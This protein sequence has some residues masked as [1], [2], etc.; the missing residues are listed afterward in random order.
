MASLKE[1]SPSVYYINLVHIEGGVTSSLKNVETGNGTVLPL[2]VS[3]SKTRATGP[4]EAA[5]RATFENELF[6]S[7]LTSG[8]SGA[9]TVLVKDSSNK[10]FAVP[11]NLISDFDSGWESLDTFVATTNEYGLNTHS[12][13]P[14]YYAG[15]VAAQTP[16]Y[17]LVNRHMMFS[18]PLVIP[19]TDGSTGF[20][21]NYSTVI[22]STE[23][24]VATG[25]SGW[26]HDSDGN[27]DF[28][29]SP[30]L[31]QSA[32]LRPDRYRDFGWHIA[33][34]FMKVNTTS[35]GVWLTALVRVGVDTTGRIVIRSVKHMEGVT[36]ASVGGTVINSLDLRAIASVVASGDENLDWSGF[37][38]TATT[39][40]TLN[41]TQAVGLYE[42]AVSIDTTN[43]NEL[44]GFIIDLDPISYMLSTGQTLYDL[45]AALP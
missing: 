32:A 7:G 8:V 23:K 34:R 43:A 12:N 16:K 28:L 3:T 15:I 14:T 11:M 33:H 44:G 26:S 4:L 42:Y 13:I 41:N 21:G 6:A 5:A 36:Q 40:S 37:K 35:E 10:L 17:R 27:N 2:Q 9:R 30:I 18:G 38:S 22:S 25:A 24:N 19:L 31:F 39:P 29:T 45:Q 1:A 20:E